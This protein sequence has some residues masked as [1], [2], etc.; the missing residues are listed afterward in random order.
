M[1]VAES[2]RRGN[3]KYNAKC[4]YISLRPLKPIGTK[5]REAAAASGKSLQSYVLDAVD[6]Q[7]AYDDSHENEIDGKV[8]T[9][10]MCWLK[11]HG[12]NDEETIDCLAC[13]GKER[14]CQSIYDEYTCL[15]SIK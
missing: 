3:D 15:Q 4:D 14:E 12:H 9:N 7:M 2:K 1:P 5:I 13:L 10:L 6:R 8:I 11:E